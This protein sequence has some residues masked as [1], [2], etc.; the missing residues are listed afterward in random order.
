LG[1]QPSRYR[2][3]AGGGGPAQL[4]LA[5]GVFVGEHPDTGRPVQRGPVASQRL[6]E[7]V[8]VAAFAGRPNCG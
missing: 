3:P 7:Q 1:Q 8:R 2:R 6:I 4:D 5:D